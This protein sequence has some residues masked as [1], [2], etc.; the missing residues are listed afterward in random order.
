MKKKIG[1]LTPMIVSTLKREMEF[2]VF[3]EFCLF[4]QQI[5]LQKIFQDETN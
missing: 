4:S 2:V 3:T 5:I 1:A